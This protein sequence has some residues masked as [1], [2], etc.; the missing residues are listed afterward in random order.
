MLKAIVDRFN[1]V[2]NMHDEIVSNAIKFM[3][4]TKFPNGGSI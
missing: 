2:F 1:S 3:F 4:E